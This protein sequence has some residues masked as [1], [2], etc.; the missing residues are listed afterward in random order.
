MCQVKTS[1]RGTR[2][3]PRGHALAVL[4]VAAL[5][6]TPSFANPEMKPLAAE[7][8]WTRGNRAHVAST[9]SIPVE[10]G[11]LLDF[12]VRGKT[13]AA[14]TVAEIHEAGLITARITSGTLDRVKK[15]RDIRIRTEPA[16]LLRLS[17]MRIGVP[18]RHRRCRLFACSPVWLSYGWGAPR[19]YRS[20]Q[21]AGT[22]VTSGFVRIDSISLDHAW[23]D[24]IVFVPFDDATDQEIGVDRGDVDLAIF[25]P[26]EPFRNVARRQESWRQFIYGTSP[27]GVLAAIQFERHDAPGPF[28][29]R[30][31]TADHSPTSPDSALAVLNREAFSGDLLPLPTVWPRGIRYRVDQNLP[32]AGSMEDALDRAFARAKGTTPDTTLLAYLNAEP[33]QPESLRAEARSRMWWVTPEFRDRVTRGDPIVV[34]PLFRVRFPLVASTP[35]RRLVRT[36]GPDNFAALLDCRP[37]YPPR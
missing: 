32:G 37:M 1:H 6:A 11:D 13:A 17:T 29:T 20:T 28:P 26:G 4:V 7:V 30:R 10:V 5:S 8:V 15:L 34:T 12:Q 35:I 18:G 23:P 24:T 25:W 16:P 33:D 19:G 21:F 36:L 22:P 2:L 9:D 3:C 31:E 27:R 14:G